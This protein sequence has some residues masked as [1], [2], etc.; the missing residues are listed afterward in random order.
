LDLRWNHLWHI[1]YY[2]KDLDRQLNHK[3]Y[4]EYML[5][6]K[7]PYIIHYAGAIKPWKD[8]QIDLAEIWWKYAKQTPFYE[9]LLKHLGS[10]QNIRNIT[11]V[12]NN[13]TTQSQ[14]VLHSKI[15]LRFL[16]IVPL[17]KKKITVK[18]NTLK[19]KIYFLGIPFLKKT[20]TTSKKKIR[21]LGVPIWAERVQFPAKTKYY[22]CGIPLF[23][24]KK[25]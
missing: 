19:T 4:D 15:V 3:T 8:T 1:P 2:A 6:G 11:N 20:E 10:I 5:A 21:F 16:S 22:F 23:K 12:V 18:R 17:Y 24:V 7:N 25:Y 9:T 13:S 14:N